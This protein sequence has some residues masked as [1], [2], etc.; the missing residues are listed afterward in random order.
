MKM[1]ASRPKQRKDEKGREYV[2]PFKTLATK[3]PPPV[4]TTTQGASSSVRRGS[5]F[6]ENQCHDL[7][8]HANRR[9][10]PL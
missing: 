6:H 2:G 8:H 9:P 3:D 5:P 1:K 7:G 4:V 10:K